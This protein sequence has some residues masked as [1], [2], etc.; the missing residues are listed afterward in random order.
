MSENLQVAAGHIISFGA[1]VAVIAGILPTIAALGAVI[2]YAIAIFETKTVQGFL[3]RTGLKKHT[4]LDRRATDR[5]GTT[6]VAK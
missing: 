2:W 3:Y 6:H 1:T 5:R 4:R